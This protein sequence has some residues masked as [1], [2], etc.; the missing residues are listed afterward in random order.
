[1]SDLYFKQTVPHVA[2]GDIF[3]VIPVPN[4]PACGAQDRLS[5]TSEL[6][7]TCRNCGVI[8]E[9]CPTPE[10]AKDPTGPKP[11]PPDSGGVAQPEVKSRLD[12]LMEARDKFRQ[13]FYEPQ[14][15]AKAI[16]YLIAEI[17]MLIG[18]LEEIKLGK[19]P[20]K[21]DIGKFSGGLR[22]D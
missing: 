17:S 8:F 20:D 18:E 4:C 7:F 22:A 19:R 10:F 3:L 1:M 13:G 16:L 14:E 5:Q 2:G 15:Q 6:H 11:S 9:E 12:L 21:L